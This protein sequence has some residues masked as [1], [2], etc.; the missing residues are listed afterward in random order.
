MARRGSGRGD[1][2]RLREELAAHR[3]ALEADYLRQGMAPEAARRAARLKLGGEDQIRQQWRAARRWAWLD[4]LRRDLAFALRSLRR[5]PGF[6]AIA[7]TVLALGIGANTA[8]FSLVN[9]VLLE[10][11]PFA[12][13]N[14]LVRLYET[15][16][17][18]GS[19][20]LSGPDFPDWRRQAALFAGMALLAPP[21]G[22]NLTGSGEPRQITRVAA[23]DNFF[24]LLGVRPALG[25]L[26]RAGD[27]GGVAVLSYP[28]WQS[29]FGGQRGI[30]GQSITLD[31]YN[32][33]V[34]GVAPAH[35][36]VRTGFTVQ[37]WVPLNMAR[38]GERGQHSFAAIGRL[39]P[40]VTLAQ[41]RVQMAA[42]AARLARQY[43]LTNG[44][45]GAHVFWLRDR[46]VPA[47]QRASLLTLLGAVGLILL[48]ACAN[49]ANMLL[50]RALTRRKEISIRRALGASRGRIVRQLLAESLLLALVGA[51][52]G[53]ALAWAG[54]RA[55][56]GLRA[57][58][59][60]QF[61]PVAVNGPVLAFTAGLA[62]VCGVLFGL[63]PALHSS[64]FARSGRA[65]RLSG[66]L[67]AA[68]VALSLV[69]LAVAGLFLE[70]YARLRSS[71][72][73]VN[74]AHVLIAQL[75]LP[76]ARYATPASI[77]Q[78]HAALLGRL[79]AQPGIGAA[80]TSS[81]IP[82]EGSSNGQISLPG[83]AAVRKTLVEQTDITPSYFSTMQIPLLRGRGYTREDAAAYARFWAAWEAHA[84]PATL[85]GFQLGIVVNQA[86]ADEFFPGRN[87]IGERFRQG[88]QG[89]WLTIQG[90]VGNVAVYALGT[91]PMP[92]EY[93]PVASLDNGFYLELRSA[94]PPAAAAGSLRRTVA[95]LDAT[96]PLA[97]IQTMNQVA[98]GSVASQAFQ[99]WLLSGFAALALL[100]ALAGIYAVMSFLVEAR[101][102]EIGVRMAL[103]A[104]RASVL[105]LVVGRGL[106][107]AAIGIACGLAAALALGRLLASQLYQVS[108]AD[109]ATLA[110]AAALLAAACLL[111]CA[112]PAR[113]AAAL[114]PTRTLRTE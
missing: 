82:L 77:A 27:T 20:P 22:A 26:L 88:R 84:T 63:A 100:L 18:R 29:Q 40:G 70:S 33:T 12:H 28:F 114:D 89:P 98:D 25:R 69:L 72:L 7:I 59:L 11:L 9:A 4:D 1:E 58:T 17:Q 13:P 21:R 96:L 87:P 102:R 76:A 68:E 112:V 35:F 37:A 6:T 62:V 90:V 49:L 75:N 111:A 113:R 46:L 44:H 15:Q 101:R 56:V 50:A 48:I 36:Q 107:L 34:I 104:S 73:G 109:P 53:A 93:F 79:R 65:H 95:S 41:A 74:P 42:I 85:A 67:V 32:V 83:D 80:A 5:A 47:A 94:L 91:A 51:A 71:P 52:L 8:M 92:G 55:A 38:L 66:A 108:P 30:L 23:E 99:Q 54:V 78:F 105:A 45:T 106:R 103:G 97:V 31:G 86:F 2:R 43:P 64:G 110:A 81:A 19:W 57:F 10:P 24:Q 60:P 16:A 39:R 61:N 3:D 14:Q